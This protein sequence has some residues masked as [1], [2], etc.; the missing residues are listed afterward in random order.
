MLIAGSEAGMVP[1]NESTVV[2][3]GALGPGEMIAVDLERKILLHDKELKDELV[4]SAPFDDWASKIIDL[5]KVTKGKETQYYSGGELRTRQMAA[6]YSMEELEAILA[7][8]A[9]DGK[10]AIAS[11][12]D[13]TPSAV[14]SKNTVHYHIILG[15]TFL[16]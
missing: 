1:I 10:E 4:D 5:E 3:I 9:E 15:K 12:G 11:M 8:M 13:D 14:L 2:E 7:P 6:G 16:K